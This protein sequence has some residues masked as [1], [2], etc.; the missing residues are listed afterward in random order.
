MRRTLVVPWTQVVPRTLVVLALALAL[1][2]GCGGGLASAKSDFKKGRIADAKAKLDPLEEESHGWGLQRR[3]EFALYYGLVQSSVG[4]RGQAARWLNEAK[5]IEDAHP[6]TLS[7]E[8]RVR[9]QLAL[10]S[11]TTSAPAFPPSSPP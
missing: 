3:A 11:V 10:E 5:A 9:L 6:R 7:E 2:A 1:A 4:D 8:D